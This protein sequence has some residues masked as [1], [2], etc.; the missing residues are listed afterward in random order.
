MK[1][2]ILY[3]VQYNEQRAF[4]LHTLDFST[5]FFVNLNGI[6]ILD[7]LITNYNQAH[8]VNTFII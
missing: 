8:T 7:D 6:N 3:S 5:V 4:V 2:G 1:H